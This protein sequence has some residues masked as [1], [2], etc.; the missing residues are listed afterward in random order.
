MGHTKDKEPPKLRTE[1][2]RFYSF[3]FSCALRLRTNTSFSKQEV[4]KKNSQNFFWIWLSHL[5]SCSHKIIEKWF[6][7]FHILVSDPKKSCHNKRLRTRSS[8][9]WM[10]LAKLEVVISIININYLMEYI[11]TSCKMNFIISN[12]VCFMGHIKA[13][14]YTWKSWCVVH[15]TDWQH[16]TYVWMYSPWTC[17]FVSQAWGSESRSPSVYTEQSW[18]A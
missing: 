12:K 5:S 6:I 18:R 13:F 9:L 15:A 14:L 7:W 16:C 8:L 11:K 3:P 17:L 1:C 10:P 2:S 4:I